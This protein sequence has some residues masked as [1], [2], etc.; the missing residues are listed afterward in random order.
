[1]RTAGWHFRA[2]RRSTTR[3]KDQDL[4]AGIVDGANN[5]TRSPCRR[6]R[7]PPAAL[8]F[9]ATDCYRSQVPTIHWSAIMSSNSLRAIPHSRA[10]QLLANCR[11]SNPITGPSQLF[12]RRYFEGAGGAVNA[13]SLAS[14]GSCTIPSGL[15]TGGDHVEIKFDLAHHGWRL[16]FPGAAGRSDY[17]AA[18]CRRRGCACIG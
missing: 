1:M 9:I 2:M 7:I 16:H 12:A 8:M 3:F 5:I 17:S 14:L 4:P 10:T 18:N 13:T 6:Y 11:L 15:L